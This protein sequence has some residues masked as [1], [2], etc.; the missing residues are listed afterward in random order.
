MSWAANLFWMKKNESTPP[1]STKPSIAKGE[2]V[3]V[4]ANTL[5]ECVNIPSPIEAITTGA[6]LKAP[7]VLAEL[8]IQINVDSIVNLPEPALEI[9]NIK[10]NLK[11]TQCLLLQDTNMLFIKGFI[12]K[13]IDYSTKGWC[14]NQTGFCGD[15]RHCTVDV[16]FNCST[17]VTF[18]GTSPLPPIP[19][20]SEEFKF[21]KSQDVKGAD[22]SEKSKLLSNDLTEFN[23]FSNEFFN[24]LPF[25]ELIQSRIVEY[26]EFLNP[27]PAA[28]DKAPFE[29]KEFHRFEEKMVIYVTVKILQNRQVAVPPLLPTDC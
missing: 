26:D 6:V 17:P 24:E 11:I 3:N 21:F 8:T 9:K 20:F 13:N 15:I 19:G 25:C 29:E 5:T 14:S 7:V 2:C 12:R 22:F 28:V 16:P 4:K 10:K 1:V 27:L 18:N 23:Q